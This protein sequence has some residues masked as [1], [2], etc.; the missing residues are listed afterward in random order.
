MAFS[1]LLFI[2]GILPITL[3]LYYIT[4]NR[5]VR[6]WVLI[7]VSMLFYAW[8]EPRW[9]MILIASTFFNYLMA[10]LVEELRNNWKGKAALIAAVSEN[11]LLLTFFKYSGFI[12]D[13]INS[14]FGSSVQV[15]KLM[16]PIGIS[17][18]TFQ[19]ISYVVD[20]YRGETAAQKSPFKLLLFV[21]L[22]RQS[23]PISRY[24]DIEDSIDNRVETGR[25]VNYGVGR[26][27]TGLGKKVILANTAGKAAEAF[28]GMDYSELPV[29]GAWVAIILFAFQI[30]F[31]FSG[32]TDIA[33]GLAAMFGF[34]YNE[35]FNYPYIATSVTD[36]RRRWHISLSSFFRD[37]VYIP[38]GGNRHRHY[39]NLFAVWMLTVFGTASWNF[40][41]WGLYYFVLLLIEKT[42]L[43][44][45]LERVPAAVSRIYL[46]L[47]VLIGWVFFYHTDISRAFQ[48]IGIMFGL[49]KT[50]FMSLEADIHF[51]NNAVFL[52]IAAVACTPLF[53]WLYE[54][55]RMNVGKTGYFIADAFAKSAYNVF[56]LVVS[57]IFLVGQSYNPFLYFKF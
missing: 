25:S 12:A 9:V 17:F 22:F 47:V 7:L 3:G 54:K 20:V 29:V 34:K 18:Y 45:V 42:L 46:C 35:N 36:F 11:V 53:K 40:V 28:F 27:I 15:T 38:L 26:F 52:I 50:P 19:T 23:G 5:T 51:W 43:K 14:I 48:F 57:I 13:N 6:N 1:S 33:I 4:K 31:D 8:S 32:Y 49:G 56:I 30:Y 55:F 44:K 2:C 10:L 39:L 41:G 21:S 37:Y 16:L 24:K